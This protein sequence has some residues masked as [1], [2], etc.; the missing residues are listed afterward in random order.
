[1]QDALS[2]LEFFVMQEIFFS[3]TC[4][5]A[6]VI[7]PASPSLILLGLSTALLFFYWY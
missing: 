5:F 6:D 3:A 1:V 7:F 4:K 2:K